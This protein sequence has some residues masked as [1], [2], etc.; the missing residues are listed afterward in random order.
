VVIRPDWQG[1]A[2]AVLAVLWGAFTVSMFGWAPDSRWYIVLLRLWHSVW[3]AGL[4]LGGLTARIVVDAEGLS[5]RAW[6]RTRRWSWERLAAVRLDASTILLRP[7]DG[8]P[9]GVP[10]VRAAHAALISQ[11]L[12]WMLH[13]PAMRPG[14][15]PA[16]GTGGRDAAS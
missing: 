2:A 13:N 16:P 7:A 6:G 3:F 8:P 5:A 1:T 11:N 9:M 14:A 10:L 4:G 15:E 12:A